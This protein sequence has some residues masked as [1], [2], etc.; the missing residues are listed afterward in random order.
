MCRDMVTEETFNEFLRAVGYSSGNTEVL[1]TAFENLAD[2]WSTYKRLIDYLDIASWDRD[3][4]PARIWAE[5]EAPRRRYIRA[6]SAYYVQ[7][8]VVLNK[9]GPDPGA[10]SSA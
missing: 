9:L 7:L 5:L 8:S 3:P 4:S 2:V 1:K 10:K 6:L